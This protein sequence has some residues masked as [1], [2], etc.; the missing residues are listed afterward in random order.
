MHGR[1]LSGH[2]PS[3]P[4][5]AGTERIGF[6]L[7]RQTSRASTAAGGGTLSLLALD[8]DHASRRRLITVRTPNTETSNIWAFNKGYVDICDHGL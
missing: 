6:S 1:S 4:Y 5:N 7:T 8:L 3:H 2:R